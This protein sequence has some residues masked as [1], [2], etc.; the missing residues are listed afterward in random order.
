M[1]G[2]QLWALIP[3]SWRAAVSGRVDEAAVEQLA[4]GLS[5]EQRA[6]LPRPGQ[7]FRALKVTPL[8]SVRAVILGQDPYPTAGHAEGL[9]FSLAAGTRHVAPSLRRI[10][11]EAERNALVLPG[12]TSLLPWA[13]RGVLLLNTVLTVPEG[14]PGGH[15]NLGWQPLTAAILR[16]VASQSAPVVFLAWGAQARAAVRHA[17][18]TDGNPHL[19]CPSVHPMERRGSFMGSDPFGRANVRLGSVGLDPIDWSLD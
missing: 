18:I 4:R 13:R 16:A 15:V 17:G 6:V 3:L 8:G 9:A 12:N 5:T 7:W 11:R 2:D 14:V 1:T 10:L 19:V